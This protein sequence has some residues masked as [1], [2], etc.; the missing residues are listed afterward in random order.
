MINCT[1]AED[2]VSAKG[3]GRCETWRMRLSVIC[4]G[5]EVSDV[6]KDAAR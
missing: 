5:D 3:K 2:M 1:S 6:E 4:I